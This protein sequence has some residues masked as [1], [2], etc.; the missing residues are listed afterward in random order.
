MGKMPLREI[1]MWSA[2][3]AEHHL[4]TLKTYEASALQIQS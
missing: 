2:Y 3:H 4:Q 1:I